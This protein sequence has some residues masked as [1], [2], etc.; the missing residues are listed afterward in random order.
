METF[1]IE[2]VFYGYHGSM[3]VWVPDWTQLECEAMNL[4]NPTA[5]KKPDR[6]TLILLLCFTGDS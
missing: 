6:I 3:D 2:S 4:H 1:D 5:V